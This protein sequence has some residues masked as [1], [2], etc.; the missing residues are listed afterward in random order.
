[1]LKEQTEGGERMK[2][3]KER[4]AQAYATNLLIAKANLDPKTGIQRLSYEDQAEARKRV[5][6][7][8]K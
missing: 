5:D 1:M 3:E 6:A 2:H 7:N 8:E 4:D